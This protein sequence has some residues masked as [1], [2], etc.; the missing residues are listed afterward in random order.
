MRSEPL[1]ISILNAGGQ[2]DYLFGY[3]SGLAQFSNLIIEVVDGERTVGKFDQFANVIHHNLRGPEHTSTDSIATKGIRLLKFYF[4]LICYPIQTKSRIFHIQWMNKFLWFDRTVLLL[5]YKICGKELY[6]TAHN[7]NDRARDGSDT[8]LNKWSL[9]FLYRNL[10]GVF[11]HTQDMKTELLELCPIDPER[12]K[13]IPHGINNSMTPSEL[14]SS[15]ARNYFGFSEE[16]KLVLFFGQ[17]GRYKGLDIL[18]EAFAALHP[19]NPDMR[20][21]ILGK[22][23]G[24]DYLNLIEEM[25]AKYGLEELVYKDFSYVDSDVVD[26]A[27][28]AADCVVMPYRKIYQSGVIFL[29]LRYGLPVIATK[30]GVFTEMIEEGENGLLVEEGSVA[31]IASALTQYFNIE[32]YRNLA[33]RRTMIAQDSNQKYSWLVIGKRYL[34]IFNA[35]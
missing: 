15:E 16:H 27:F 30:V 28:I 7:I 9:R 23:K 5:W 25:I 17:I 31:N 33:N 14:S 35:D 21:V 3:I 22:S 11:V 34:E 2:A 19:D 12:V 8:W 20:L 32:L 4:K 13:V 1:R 6:Y 24:I 10:R 26:K 18:I 29:A